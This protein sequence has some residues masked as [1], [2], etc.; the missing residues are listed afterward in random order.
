MES[1]ARASR[2]AHAPVSGPRVYES[3]ASATWPGGAAEGV[4]QSSVP[5]WSLRPLADHDRASG[6]RTQLDPRRSPLIDLGSRAPAPQRGLGRT[7]VPGDLRKVPVRGN[8]EHLVGLLLRREVLTGLWTAAPES[9]ARSATGRW[10]GW[11]GRPNSAAQSAGAARN[12]PTFL[13]VDS[14][15]SALAAVLKTARG[16]LLEGSNPSASATRAEVGLGSGARERRRL[17]RASMRR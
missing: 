10:H 12:S 6:A 7:Q 11:I 13:R 3:R 8:Q 14:S 17:R 5:K 15:P 4:R 9:V 2:W 1:L 16:Q